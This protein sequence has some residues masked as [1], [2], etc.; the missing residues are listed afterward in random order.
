MEPAGT[1]KHASGDPGASSQARNAHNDATHPDIAG[2]DA[3]FGYPSASDTAFARPVVNKI[4]VG[5]IVA[6]AL[7]LGVVIGLSIVILR[8]PNVYVTFMREWEDIGTVCPEQSIRQ[9]NAML[10]YGPVILL[11]N[12]TI[13]GEDGKV[14]YPL[15]QS[16]ELS[17]PPTHDANGNHVPSKIVDIFWWKTPGLPPGRY[18]RVVGAATYRASVP[19]IT[20]T[21][22]AIEECDDATNG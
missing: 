22:F 19:S 4:L 2:I 7:V 9:E 17:V 11:V 3:V 10:A 13:Y 21:E 8:G 18:Q 20:V 16:Y 15:V 12:A 6:V 1:S 14:F 5:L